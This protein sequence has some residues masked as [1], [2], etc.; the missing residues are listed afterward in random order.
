MAERK[1]DLVVFDWDGTL[2]DSTA[3]IVASIQAACAEVGV[4]VPSFTT[5]RLTARWQQSRYWLSATLQDAT[6][7]RPRNLVATDYAPIASMR[8]DGRTC[9]LNAGLR[10]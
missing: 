9:L 10:F 4:A 6:H 3:L 5:L 2:M 1:F 8:E 7:A